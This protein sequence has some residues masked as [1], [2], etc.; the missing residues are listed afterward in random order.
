MAPA[1][2][3]RAAGIARI[4]IGR[5]LNHMGS[6]AQTQFLH[7]LSGRRGRRR[8]QPVFIDLI[9]GTGK[10]DG[11]DRLGGLDII[12]VHQL[13]AGFG[14]FLIHRQHGDII[15]LR[16]GADFQR[17][18]HVPPSAQGHPGLGAFLFDGLDHMIV[19]DDVFAVINDKTAAFSHQTAAL[20]DQ[21]PDGTVFHGFNVRFDCGGYYRHKRAE[22][23]KQER[24][25]QHQY[26][27]Q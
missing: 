24:E 2:E 10:A 19:C 23:R 16:S 27:P 8:I 12:A 13:D 11:D 22:R 18:E 17:P 1:V 3:Y 7:D 20:G 5:D 21:H 6:T 25:R 14:Q 15:G 9:A 4:D 26:F